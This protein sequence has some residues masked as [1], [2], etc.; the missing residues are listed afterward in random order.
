MKYKNQLPQTHLIDK[1]NLI[2]TAD[3]PESIERD[4]GDRMSDHL[5]YPP[6][7]IDITEKQQRKQIRTLR[8]CAIAKHIDGCWDCKAFSGC[9]KILFLQKKVL[10]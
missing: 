6:L 1:K 8:S 9:R 10:E 3:N 4:I 7:I 2:K 5:L